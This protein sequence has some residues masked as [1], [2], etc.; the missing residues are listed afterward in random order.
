MLPLPFILLTLS[1]SFS[2]P[3]LSSFVP[4][5]LS[6]PSTSLSQNRFPSSKTS[7]LEVSPPPRSS[8]F[9]SS[10]LSLRIAPI[11]SLSFLS[12]SQFSFLFSIPPPLRVL[13]PSSL[14]LVFSSLSLSFISSLSSSL[15]CLYIPKWGHIRLSTCRFPFL[16]CPSELASSYS[17]HLSAHLP[18]ASSLPFLHPSILASVPFALSRLSHLLSPLLPISLVDLTSLL[19]LPILHSRTSRTDSFIIFSPIC[20]SS[21][22]LFHFASSSPT[23]SSSSLLFLVPLLSLL[24]HQLFRSSVLCYSS[25]LVSIRIPCSLHSL[26][27]ST[28]SSLSVRCSLFCP[29][30]RLSE[31]SLSFLHHMV[32]LSFLLLITTPSLTSS[33]LPCS[34]QI[35]SS[36]SLSF[37]LIFD[38]PSSSPFITLVPS[39]LIMHGLHLPCLPQFPLFVSILSIWYPPSPSSLSLL[40]LLD[41]N[42]PMSP[43]EHIPAHKTTTQPPKT[44]S[45][46][47]R[48]T[49]NRPR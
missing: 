6:L 22:I 30:F 25:R 12:R 28:S 15:S 21:L 39:S 10:L 29:C 33:P 36:L 42:N 1:L 44:A 3:A 19:C 20:H 49:V 4:R 8:P 38:H 40:L 17:P 14:F 26:S 45:H 23:L 47:H 11:S 46:A 24:S 13:L 35:H 41:L 43:P 18:S 48:N 2:S 27:L 9:L 5:R 32:L 7:Q 16:G 37:S 34:S 31:I